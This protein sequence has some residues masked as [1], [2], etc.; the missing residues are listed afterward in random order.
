VTHLAA[1]AGCDYL[2]A[3]WVYSHS[4]LAGLQRVT[5]SPIA[6]IVCYLAI[7]SALTAAQALHFP[8]RMQESIR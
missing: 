5:P 2:H 7:A 1:V 8:K 6:I 4:S 3:D